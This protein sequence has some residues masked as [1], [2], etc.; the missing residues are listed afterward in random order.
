MLFATQTYVFPRH[1]YNVC[2][3][4][5]YNYWSVTPEDET[6]RSRINR[7]YSKTYNLLPYDLKSCNNWQAKEHYFKINLN[8]EQFK[9]VKSMKS[10]VPTYQNSIRY[11]C[12]SPISNLKSPLSY[13]PCWT[14]CQTT[15]CSKPPRWPARCYL[16]TI[17]SNWWS[18]S[19]A[20]KYDGLKLSSLI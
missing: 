20:A 13:S 8:G 6:K 12:C 4:S 11:H 3:Q 9:D 16:N 5:T 1:I 15:D 18:C 10:K 14:T 19:T 17:P 2:R 7:R